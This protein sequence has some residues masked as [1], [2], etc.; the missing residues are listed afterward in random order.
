MTVPH[1]RTS[2]A[3]DLSLFD[4]STRK[5]EEPRAEKAP[6]L[7]VATSSAAKA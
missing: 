5:K 2:T 6:E 1:N 4:T 3:Y 7:K